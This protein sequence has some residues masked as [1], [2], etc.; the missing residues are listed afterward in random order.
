MKS[1][2]SEVIVGVRDLV[3]ARFDAQ[4]LSSAYLERTRLMGFFQF[5]FQ[6]IVKKWRARTRQLKAVV[7]TRQLLVVQ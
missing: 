6:R 2:F 1:T 4:D 3:G 5:T 7:V